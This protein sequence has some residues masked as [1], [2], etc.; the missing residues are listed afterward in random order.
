MSLLIIVLWFITLPSSKSTTDSR[1]HNWITHCQTSGKDITD[2]CLKEFNQW[3]EIFSRNEPSSD[4]QIICPKSQIW[5]SLVVCAC[6]KCHNTFF[7]PDDL[8]VIWT[9]SQC[10]MTNLNT[11]VDLCQWI[12][13]PSTTENNTHSTAQQLEHTIQEILVHIHHCK[14]S[15]TVQNIQQFL[16]LFDQIIDALISIHLTTI[17]PR[18][19]KQWQA[20]VTNTFEAF[21]HTQSKIKAEEDALHNGLKT[22]ESKQN[23]MIE[24]LQILQQLENHFNIPRAQNQTQ[25][26]VKQLK[27]LLLGIQDIHDTNSIKKHADAKEMQTF[28]SKGIRKLTMAANVLSMISNETESIENKLHQHQ[29][30]LN[31]VKEIETEIDNDLRDDRHH[32]LLKESKEFH[33]IMDEMRTISTSESYQQAITTMEELSNEWKIATERIITNIE[34]I[35]AKI[36]DLFEHIQ[37]VNRSEPFRFDED[38]ADMTVEREP[39]VDAIFKDVWHQQMKTRHINRSNVSLKYDDV[40]IDEELD[41]ESAST[42]MM[43]NKTLVYGWTVFVGAIV[44]CFSFFMYLK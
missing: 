44:L 25:Q 42:D 14:A 9:K 16:H 15:P 28:W 1:P 7:I 34:R 13:A 22:I 23:E 4:R 31:Y 39:K 30:S 32:L 35:E 41:H 27:D 2:V 36:T 8:T 6:D 3:I 20:N 24:D 11:S 19:L 37:S 21:T 12:K 17:S 10:N 38:S 43:T 33:Q 26:I 40:T 5:K 29:L 18:V